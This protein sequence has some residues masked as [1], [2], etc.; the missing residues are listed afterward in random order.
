MTCFNELQKCLW[1]VLVEKGA[2][3]MFIIYYI[4]TT[5]AAVVL[6]SAIYLLLYFWVFA[7]LQGEKTSMTLS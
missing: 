1:E 3:T 6:H 5:D 4:I 7:P 2:I